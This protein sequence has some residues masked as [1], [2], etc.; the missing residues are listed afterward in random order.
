MRYPQYW[1]ATA[2]IAP[3]AFGMQPS[4]LSTISNMPMM[5]VHGDADTA[6]PVEVG[7]SW[8]QSMQEL[9]MTHRYIEVP[10][11]D[12]GDVISIGMPDIFA[13]FSTHSKP[14]SR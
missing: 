4:S 3:A 2:S 11:G 9:K 12:H 8:A 5:I 6:V 10:G 14:A 7:R 1:A 13:F